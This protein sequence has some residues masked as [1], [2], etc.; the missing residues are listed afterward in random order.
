MH[1]IITLN[2]NHKLDTPEN[3]DKFISAEIP[4]PE[5]NKKLHDLVMKHMLHGP[6]GARCEENGKCSK[7]F[8]K[9]F[10]EETIINE[11]NYTTYKRRDNSKIY[12]KNGSAF[13]N[14]HVVPYNANLLLKYNCHINVEKIASL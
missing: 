6:C 13:H 2:D 8:P 4:C 12:Y 11:D 9:G 5:K 3:V 1:L 10:Q 7:R 14:G